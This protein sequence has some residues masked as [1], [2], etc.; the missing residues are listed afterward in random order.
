MASWGAPLDPQLSIVYSQCNGGRLGELIV[1]GAEEGLAGLAQLNASLRADAEPYLQELLR[2]AQFDGF[3]YY[4]ATIP[5]LM[6]STGQQPVVQLS[7]YIDKVIYP[8]A[9]DV[10]RAFD[11]YAHYCEARLTTYGT[12]AYEPRLEHPNILFPTSFAAKVAQDR[13]LVRMLEEGRFEEFI[14]PSP[15]SRQWVEA[16]LQAARG[17]P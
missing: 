8:I 11:L 14:A 10:D 3:E 17:L 7:D 2:F 15:D 1:F 4:L 12:L 16:V 5:R 9:S 13:E 6:S